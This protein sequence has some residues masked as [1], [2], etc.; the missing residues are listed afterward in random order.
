MNNP[1]PNQDQR[2]VDALIQGS[3]QKVKK[4]SLLSDR[5][6]KLWK[7][8]LV[9]IF[10]AGAGASGGLLIK[11]NLQQ[12]TAASTGGYV[13]PPIVDTSS[14][15]QVYS[16]AF[17]VPGSIQ[18]WKTFGDKGTWDVKNGNLVSP[19]TK[20]DHGISGD[21]IPAL[22]DFEA[23]H[24][25][26]FLKNHKKAEGGLLFGVQPDRSG[27]LLKLDPSDS[28]WKVIQMKSGGVP[29]VTLGQ[30]KVPLKLG[31]WYTV[32]AVR[33]GNT[34]WLT[35]SP[36]A[37]GSLP[38]MQQIAV[39]LPQSSSGSTAGVFGFY[40][41]DGQVSYDNLVVKKPI[42]LPSGSLDVSV[43]SGA[44]QNVI[45]G[46]TA[47]P[48][49]SMT[50]DASHS[51]SDI[52]VNQLEISHHASA[53]GVHQLMTNLTLFDGSTQ[54]S[55][56][57]S[58]EPNT[59]YLDATTTIPLLVPLTIQKGTMKQLFLRGDFSET[60]VSGQS[61]TF[62]F[63]GSMSVS[64]VALPNNT[65]IKPMVAPGYGSV[66]T[67]VS[68]GNLTLRNS[69]QNNPPERFVTANTTGQ[70]LQVFT[71]EA[72]GEG[73]QLLKM[74]FGFA[75]KHGTNPLMAL[76]TAYLYDGTTLLGSVPVAGS[77]VTFALS[78][79]VIPEGSTK[80]FTLKA[81]VAA[82]GGQNPTSSGANVSSV[83]TAYDAKGV[84]SG[85]TAVVKNGYPFGS[86]ITLVKSLPAVTKGSVSGVLV[87]GSQ[88][89]LARFNIVADAKGDIGLY[90]PSFEI[91][92]TTATIT[93]FI[94]IEDPDGTAR[95]LTMD[96]G[97]KV[98]ETIIPT[99]A[100]NGSVHA[101]DMFIDTTGDGVKN[102]GEYVIIPAGGTRVYELRGDV[103]GVGTGSV[104][105]IDL[106]S[107][108]QFPN[109][110]P[111]CAGGATTGNNICFGLVK[112]SSNFI[113]S[114]LNFGLS[115]STAT[116]SSE[117][118]SGY[119]IFATTTLQVLTK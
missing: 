78:N 31:T 10:F 61:H 67:I 40:S 99:P 13:Q 25:L 9:A 17:E 11:S 38:I 49:L 14:W 117:W 102:G 79:V 113:W 68:V 81:D 34:L 77:S 70:T 109:N 108:A 74:T 50:F 43:V 20:N 105:K 54:V 65:Q 116:N 87:N 24:T 28:R 115:S 76:D 103:V 63:T 104:V 46:S 41:E 83:V 72:K 8:M 94:L 30:G 39:A 112:E 58:G 18:Q 95:N 59:Q 32:R 97:R 60:S 86:Q 55:V 73:I 88:V 23:T 51:M 21:D 42:P 7:V 90:L 53:A 100:P 5:Q 91:S 69:G 27:Y 92:T 33:S 71:A 62:G 37:A 48:L 52:S 106:R 2:G 47:V 45:A 12:D 96:G 89:P 107:D 64:A 114:D 56:P 110:Y 29:G 66:F 6:V 15:Q 85:S 22:T 75:S 93:K 44:P 119:Q 4:M 26:N 3:Q 19:V 111:N 98:T 36:S 118:F 80:E 57:R 1:S 101:L 84:V 35:I 16:N 82:V